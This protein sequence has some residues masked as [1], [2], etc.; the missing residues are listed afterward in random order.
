MT[1][2]LIKLCILDVRESLMIQLIISLLFCL[3]A[4]AEEAKVADPIAVVPPKGKVPAH[5]LLWAE[6]PN[7]SRFAVVA[8]KGQRTL[9]LWSKHE[10]LPQLVE[11]F[12]MDMGKKDGDKEVRGDHKTPEGIYFPQQIFEGPSLNFDEY[13]VRAFEL[14]YPNFF[15]RRDRKTGDGIWLHAI[16]DTKSLM[17]GSRGCVVVRNEIIDRLTPKMDLKKTPVI[18]TKK[19]KY[20]SPDKHTAQ[21]E[22][23]VAW[24][25]RWRKAWTSKN[26]DAYMAF[27]HDG[28]NALNRNKAAWR[29]Y[30]A[31]LNERYENIDVRTINPVAFQNE[32]DVVLKF[33]QDYESDSLKDFGQKTLF[34]EFDGTDYKIRGEEWIKANPEVLA[35]IS[36]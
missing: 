8:D 32:K 27:Y 34:L 11:A 18:I 23:L 26:I 31:A 13:G 33:F 10:G 21:A 6:G 9:S 22:A 16:P 30:K 20:V 5:L 25:D 19:A 24:L 15:D 36:N 3:T 14:D 7:H 28:F 1:S 12:P 17:R 4:A 29:R 2:G 35:H